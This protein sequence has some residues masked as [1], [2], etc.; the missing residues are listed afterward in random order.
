MFASGAGP[1]PKVVERYPH[2]W[3]AIGQAGRFFRLA[4]ADGCRDVLFIGTMLRPP[5][6]QIRLD[7]HRSG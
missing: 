4:R 1:M 2:H 3:I 5:L 7:W 6:T